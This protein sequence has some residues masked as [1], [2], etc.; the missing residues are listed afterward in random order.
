M[1]W[2]CVLYADNTQPP[3]T[4]GE[5]LDYP[6][7]DHDLSDLSVRGVQV[8]FR[9]TRSGS[10]PKRSSFRVA[11]DQSIGTVV[12]ARFPDRRSSQV[13]ILQYTRGEDGSPPPHLP[14]S[15]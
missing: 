10:S 6:Q 1:G 7:V 11:L 9:L 14:L 13:Y 8:S 5:E 2:I 15:G 12:V 3:T 4:A